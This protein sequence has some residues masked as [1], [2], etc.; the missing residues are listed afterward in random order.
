MDVKLELV[1]VPVTDVDRAKAFYERI[2]FHADHDVTVSEEIRFVQLTPPG[3]AC[4]IAIGKGLTR[5][6]PGSLDNMQVVVADIEEAYADL[7]GRGVEVTEIQ[8]MPCG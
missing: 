4:S 2:G 7:R 8:D 5:M 6:I 1:A 3:S